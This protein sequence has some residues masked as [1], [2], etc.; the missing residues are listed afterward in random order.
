MSGGY[1]YVDQTSAPWH[2]P[3]GPLEVTDGDDEYETVAASQTAQVLGATG[4][5]GDYLKQ[6]IVTVQTSATG[7]CTIND[8]GGSEIPITPAN[9]PI[10]TY[11]I[12]LGITSVTGSWRVTTG[13]GCTVLAVGDF[14]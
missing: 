10:G 14:T 12:Q 9:I 13:A 3:R 7:T 2:S 8:G 1:P 6:L 4:A 5:A 11:V